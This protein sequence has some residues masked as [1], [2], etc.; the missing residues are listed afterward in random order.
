MKSGTL[1]V[2]IGVVLLGGGTAQGQ[3]VA[4]YQEVIVYPAQG[5]S[6]EQ[7]EKD[8]YECYQWARGQTGFD[9]MALPT[10]S[11]PPPQEKAGS[12]GG[13]GQ[14]AV[15]GAAVGAAVG[16]LRG[17]TAKWAGRGLATGALVGGARSSK[18]KQKDKQAR[19]QWEQE[20]GAQ[21]QAARDGYNRA[22][23]ACLS[24]R[25]YSVN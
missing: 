6:E 10:A 16:I 13:A 19:N 8:K 2:C 22:Y 3:D 14:G 15:K 9:P 4:V 11:R 25:G 7:A 21:Y 17:D 1:L 12:T 24:G 5:Q 18:Q 23:S 20:Q